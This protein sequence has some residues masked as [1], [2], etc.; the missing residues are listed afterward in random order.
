M[1]LFLVYR[2][3]N[4]YRRN[5]MVDILLVKTKLNEG[6]E[7]LNALVNYSAKCRIIKIISN[8]TILF[9]LLK[10]EEYLDAVVWIDEKI[11]RNLNYVEKRRLKDKTKD[12]WVLCKEKN[13]IV[14]FSCIS[15]DNLENISDFIE[16]IEIKDVNYILKNKIKKEL[17]Y[18]GYNMSYFGTKY[19]IECIYHIYNDYNFLDFTL[20]K[21]IYPIVAKKYNKN[22]H[23]VKCNITRAT[24]MM[25]YDSDERKIG[26]YLKLCITNK[27][28]TKT[29]INAVC[30]RINR[31]KL[32]ELWKN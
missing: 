21:D 9:K 4:I 5:I 11:F 13:S 2:Y 17:E 7:L 28:T 20:E 8:K 18:L 1:Q 3:S 26:E 25:F 6:V 10:T 32:G 23:N 24:N 12:V 31:K 14:D 15:L 29:I 16:Q 27:P 30:N 22:V 19:L